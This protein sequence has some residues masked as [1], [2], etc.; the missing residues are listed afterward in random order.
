MAVLTLLDIAQRNKSPEIGIIEQ[1]TIAVPEVKVIPSKIID[2]LSF[3][4]TIRTGR[5][6]GAFRNIN[7]GV[8]PSKSD[9]V[10]KEVALKLYS[11]VMRYDE[12]LESIDKRGNLETEEMMGAYIDALEQHAKALWYGANATHG[13][14]GAFPGLLDLV[15]SNMVYDATGT[16]SNA[17]ASAWLVCYGDR[18]VSHVFGNGSPFSF[19]AWGS[20]LMADP[21][22]ST[23]FLPYRTSTM[24]VYSGVAC[25][26]MYSFG[27]IKNLTAD[28]GKGLTFAKMEALKALFP[29]GKIKM[30]N[31]E[32]TSNCAWFVT[33]RSYQQLQASLTATS[34]TGMPAPYPK[35]D[36]DGI[37][38]YVTEALADTE[39]INLAGS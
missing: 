23:K 4:Q 24:N 13:V 9:Y 35:A 17:A 30:G 12:A 14:T 27:R 7:A 3:W 38:I 39:A 6:R 18:Q 20:T 34:P 1:G 19:S 16:A 5:P 8:T 10:S 28:S 32:G 11:N 22:D 33:K 15:D 37:P 26:D 36:N 21:K 31:I 25:A 2:G 29:V